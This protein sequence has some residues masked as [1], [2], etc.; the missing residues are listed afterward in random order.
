ML[1]WYM[2][3]LALYYEEWNR[4]KEKLGTMW[5]GS[6]RQFAFHNGTGAPYYYQHPYKW[7]KRSVQE[8]K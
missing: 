2:E 6:D 4:E 5:E 3:E 1:Q 8:I 7:W